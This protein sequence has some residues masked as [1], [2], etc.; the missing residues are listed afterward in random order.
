MHVV[1]RLGPE[2]AALF[3][4]LRLEARLSDPDAF[5]ASFAEEAAKPLAWFRDRLIGDPVFVAVVADGEMAG[6]AGFTPDGGSRD[7]PK[8]RVW[9][10]YVKRSWRARGVGEALVRAVVE[11]AKSIVPDLHLS[12]TASNRAARALY[13]RVGF[14]LVSIEAD[15]TN[16]VSG[17]LRDEAHYV[18][19]F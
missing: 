12:C 4:S 3:R 16:E 7:G 14:R 15:V 8:G 9:T 18:L 11:H 2:D 5:R 13:E 10:V 17:Q 6:M 19:T 1:R